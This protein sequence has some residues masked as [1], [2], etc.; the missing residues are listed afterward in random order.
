MHRE[1]SIALTTMAITNPATCVGPR[2]NNNAETEENK[3]LVEKE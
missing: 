1:V 3:R 2:N